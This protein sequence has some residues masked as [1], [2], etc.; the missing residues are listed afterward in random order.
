[1]ERIKVLIADDHHLIRKGLTDIL[2][3]AEPIEIVGDASDGAEAIEKAKSLKPDL[4]LMDLHMPRCDGAEATRRLK[5]EMPEIKVLILTISE[6]E[7]DLVDA[8]KSG[9]RGYILKNEDLGMVVQAIQ[10]VSIGGT[11]VSPAMAKNLQVDLQTEQAVAPI[12][13]AGASEDPR[14]DANATIVGNVPIDQIRHDEAVDTTESN[15][16]ETAFEGSSAGSFTDTIEGDVEVV[17]SPPVEPQD[18]LGLQTWMN[19]EASAR[20][21]E[22][23]L[24]RTGDTVIKVNLVTAT[25]FMKILAES[26]SVAEV[27]RESSAGPT[28]P[29]RFRLTLRSG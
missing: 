20:M 10:Y 28:L 11:L 26:P 27:T 18:V 6:K 17:V 12:E 23:T 9:A 19:D 13:N 5:A 16:G 4:V 22:V 24:T 1:M 7:S 2:G 8:L 14:T 29:H 15:E 3:K 25:P 21:S